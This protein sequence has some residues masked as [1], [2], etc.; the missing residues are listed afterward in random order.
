[1]MIS[2]ILLIFNLLFW[3]IRSKPLFGFWNF[4]WIYPL[5]IVVYIVA[6]SII[7]VLTWIVDDVL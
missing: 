2:T 5:E 3:L 4:V 1:M 6:Y 7:V